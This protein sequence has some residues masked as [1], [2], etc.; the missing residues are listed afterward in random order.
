MGPLGS[1]IQFAAGSKWN[2]G[3]K[4]SA[5]SVAARSNVSEQGF[6]NDNGPKRG[7]SDV[8]TPAEIA[9]RKSR[10]ERRKFRRWARWFFKI[11]NSL[12]RRDGELQAQ[13][14]SWRASRARSKKRRP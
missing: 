7:A 6:P 13:D 8:A 4:G 2:C 9:E 10:R 3:R 5:A 14:S 11:G 1:F 12:K